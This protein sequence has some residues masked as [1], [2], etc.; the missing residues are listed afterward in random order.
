[1]VAAMVHRSRWFD[2]GVM[3]LLCRSA[4]V[5]SCCWSLLLTRL[6]G[7][8]INCYLSTLLREDVTACGLPVA[9]VCH[10]A[11]R[12]DKSYYQIMRGPNGLLTTVR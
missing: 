8:R 4:R 2:N 12:G 10:G 3:A 7:P 9:V 11:R 6:A 5:S 1:M